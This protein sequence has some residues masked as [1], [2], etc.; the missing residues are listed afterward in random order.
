MSYASD[1]S[2]T[3]F[4]ATLVHAATIPSQNSVFQN[5][6]NVTDPLSI[7][8]PNQT[9]YQQVSGPNDQLSYQCAGY[10]SPDV[11]YGSCDDAWDKIPNFSGGYGGTSIFKARTYNPSSS[12]DIEIDPGNKLVDQAPGEAVRSAAYELLAQCVGAQKRG[13]TIRGF[14]TG[15]RLSITFSGYAD[16]LRNIECDRNI[17]SDSLQSYQKQAVDSLEYL[18]FNKKVLSFDFTKPA[19][20]YGYVL[21]RREPDYHGPLLVDLDPGSKVNR[22]S[23]WNIW[24]A[25]IAVYTICVQQGRMGTFINLGVYFA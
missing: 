12:E 20:S 10:K 16:Q 8:T 21:P 18:P 4:L 24:T 15:S 2:L 6:A 25:G 9:S 5:G 23:W 14:S 13:G 19:G 11:D 1:F 7:F 17:P 22:E 3:I